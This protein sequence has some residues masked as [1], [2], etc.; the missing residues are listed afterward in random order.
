MHSFTNL[1][2]FNQ[3]PHSDVLVKK[4]VTQFIDKSHALNVGGEEVK[5]IAFQIK[6]CYGNTIDKYKR[7]YID[8]QE[9][10]LDQQEYLPFKK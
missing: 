7:T 6:G 4:K 3:D 10:C 1:V 2:K 5:S 8:L 9:H